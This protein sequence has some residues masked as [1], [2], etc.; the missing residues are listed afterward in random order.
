[1]NVVQEII[2]QGLK[3]VS[4]QSKQLSLFSTLAPLVIKFPVC[5]SLTH[6]ITQTHGWEIILKC[7]SPFPA[8]LN[9]V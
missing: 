8:F 9:G 4:C 2:Q 1:M 7:V 3:S 5:L 6:L